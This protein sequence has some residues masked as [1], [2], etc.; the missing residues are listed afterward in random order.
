MELNPL[1]YIY[2]KIQCKLV[3]MFKIQD[4]IEKR[5]LIWTKRWRGADLLWPDK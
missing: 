4:L 1:K 2:N 5:L 3:F